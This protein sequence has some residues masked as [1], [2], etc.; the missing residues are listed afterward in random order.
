MANDYDDGDE[1]LVCVTE[2]EADFSKLK[3]AETPPRNSLPIQRPS[4]V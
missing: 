2:G 3:G 4:S 1:R